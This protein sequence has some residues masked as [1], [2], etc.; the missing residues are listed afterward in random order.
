MNEEILRTLANH[1]NRIS[2]LEVIEGMGG[3]AGGG[4]IVGTPGQVVKFTGVNAIGDSLV[5]EDAVNAG[6]EVPDDWYLGI[7]E[8]AG[9]LIFDLTPAPDQIK[10]ADADLNFVTAAHGIIHVDGVAAGMF[11]RADGTRYVPDTLD[12]A[13]ITDLAYAAPNLTLGLANAVGAADTVIRT[14]AT[15]LVFDAVVPD[16]IQCDDAAAAGAAAVAARRDHTHGIVCAAPGVNLSVASANA[17][18]VATSFARSDHSHAITSSSNPGA[19]ASILASDANGY[20]QLVGLGIGA[21]PGSAD[22]HFGAGTG[23]THAD[24]IAAGQFLRANG[25]RYV[26]DTLDV[27]DLTDLAYAAP[28]LTLGLANAAGVANTVI[29]TDATILAFDAVVPNVIEC[30]DAAATGA[31]TVAARRD[32]EHGIVCAVPDRLV[33]DNAQAEGSAVSFARSDHDHQITCAAPAANLS[34]STTNAEGVAANDFARSDHSHAIT[35]S[36]NPGAAASILATDASGYLQLVGLGIGA[37]CTG[38]NR[39]IV[40]DGTIIGIAHDAERIVFDAAGDISVMGADF[41][42]G[43]L[44]PAQR[45]HVE[46]AGV[47]AIRLRDSVAAEYTDIVQAGADG[48]FYISRLGT[49]GVDISLQKDG[50]LII[51][52]QGDVGIGTAIPDRLLHA[53][54]SDAVTNAVTYAHRLSHITSG[55]AAAG[56]G[57]GIEFELEDDGGGM[58]VA[59]TIEATWISAAAGSELSKLDFGV[60]SGGLVLEGHAASPNVIGGYSG[61]SVT[62]GRSACTIGGGGS[63]GLVNSITQSHGTIGGGFANIVSAVHATIVG[64]CY[65]DAKRRGQV[66][67]ASAQFAAAGDAQ[68][69][70]QQVISR[71]VT[72]S[73]ANWHTLYIDGAAVGVEIPTDTVWTFHVLIAGTTQGCTKSFGFEIVGV[74]ENDGGTTSILASTVTTIYDG[75]DTDFDARVTAN[76]PTDQVE[77]QVE[78]STAGGDTVRW[79]G[80]LRMAEVSFPA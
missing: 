27:A 40:A 63:V 36:S 35:S 60:T 45:L 58:D 49:G 72:H 67:H 3:G 29:R 76:D 11:L 15:I 18:G 2:A 41:G 54:V 32:H 78:D 56:F 62:A 57:T 22:L 5:Y 16:V 52:Q 68:G 1:G 19:A 4:P 55:A 14:D 48:D 8:A 44:A 28:N 51:G 20:L 80:T 23:I 73:D 77:I 24:G 31:A 10:I 75:D 53:E 33:P 17:E 7:T 61:N 30:D 39:V 74:A 6:W 65:A 37:A 26:P 71:S 25:V 47:V 42:V 12:V 50:D 34:V 46:S 13:D 9:R 59:A 38:A 66:A 43:T 79:V 69:T 21:A 64:G 70:I